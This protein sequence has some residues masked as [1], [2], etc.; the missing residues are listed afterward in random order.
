MHRAA[1][2][3]LQATAQMQGGRRTASLKA[4]YEATLKSNDFATKIEPIDDELDM[5]DHRVDVI[6][7]DIA[8]S[9]NS[10]TSPSSLNISRPSRTKKP[11]SRAAQWTQER[12]QA[13]AR[14]G[15]R[16]RDHHSESADPLN[17][18][19]SSEW[20]CDPNEPRYCLCNQVSYGEMVGCDNEKCTIEWFHYGCVGLTEAPKG[21]WYCPQCTQSMKRRNKVKS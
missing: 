7:E 6:S 16:E 9:D 10:V 13:E 1:A 4:S 5:S 12:M 3:A 2:A 8:G 15:Q 20:A 17:E 19:T 14:R 18:S 21:K 11:T